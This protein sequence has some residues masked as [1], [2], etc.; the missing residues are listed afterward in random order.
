M[1]YIQI[2]AGEASGG[3]IASKNNIQVDVREI[4]G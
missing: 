4:K 2:F 1:N 3:V